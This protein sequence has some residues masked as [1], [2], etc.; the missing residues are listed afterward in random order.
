[1]QLAHNMC[2]KTLICAE[3]GKTGFRAKCVYI[4]EE[5]DIDKEFYVC[6][7]TDRKR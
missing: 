6:M 1:M 4:M 5:L 3:T 7:T 2:G